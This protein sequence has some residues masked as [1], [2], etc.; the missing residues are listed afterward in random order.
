MLPHFSIHP[1]FQ[2]YMHPINLIGNTRANRRKGV[3]TFSARPDSIF[4]QHGPIRHIIDTGITEH[5]IHG[6]LLRNLGTYFPN[7]N[8]QFSLKMDL[9][10]SVWTEDFLLI[11]NHGR[12]WFQENAR[13][14]RIFPFLCVKERAVV[15]S[16]SYNFPWLH[17]CQKTDTLQFIVLKRLPVPM[18]N[19]T[20]Q[21]TDLSA[22]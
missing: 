1:S 21:P 16:N 8:T 15:S 17:R 14:L 22:L 18:K 7:D 10:T 20:F 12:C 5:I 3:S 2:F 6:F 4:F 11:P 19:V 13:V 9:M